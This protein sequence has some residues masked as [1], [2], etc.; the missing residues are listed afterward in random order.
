MEQQQMNIQELE[1]KHK[2]LQSRSEYIEGMIKK[3]Y[4][5]LLANQKKEA[6]MRQAQEVCTIE[7]IRNIQY[8]QNLT[9]YI[10]HKVKL[11]FWQVDRYDELN[12][13]KITQEI[14]FRET[15]IQKDKEHVKI[16]EELEKLYDRKLKDANVR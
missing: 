2:E 1:N 4:E 3:Q 11:T 14:S 8:R 5:E 6:E 10:Y 16:A 12:K 9:K 15:L 13:Q 7:L